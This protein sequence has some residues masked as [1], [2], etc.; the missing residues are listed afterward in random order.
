MIEL[1]QDVDFFHDLIDVVLQLM[2]IDYFDCHI[3][4]FI[5]F[6]P[7]LKYAT[8]LARTKNFSFRVD[9]VVAF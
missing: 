4:R 8:K 3:R 6:S 2:L 7:S 1:V 9:D 5:R